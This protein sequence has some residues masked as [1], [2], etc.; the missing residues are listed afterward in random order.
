ML[1]TFFE[2]GTMLGNDSLDFGGAGR[3]TTASGHWRQSV[4]PYSLEATMLWLQGDPEERFT[5]SVRTR[6]RG[7]LT[8]AD[9]MEGFVNVWVF[10]FVDPST[11][12]VVLDAEEFP[13]PDPLTPLGPFITDPAQCNPAVGCL[14]VLEFV[15]RRISTD[16][17]D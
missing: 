14:A 8:G 12:A 11:G 16:I 9:L 13:I 5:G 3:H 2:D 6:Y 4:G 1:P 17:D 7:R 10:P 15:V